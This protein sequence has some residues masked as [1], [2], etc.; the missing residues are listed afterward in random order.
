VSGAQVRDLAGLRR[1][2]SDK[3]IAGVAGGIARHL[4]IDPLLVRVL[5][6]VL[7]FFGG[8]GLIVYAACWLLAPLD[9]EPRGVLPLD[10]GSRTV[11]LA[12]A[13]LLAALSLLGD[14]LGGYGFPWPVA[15]VGLVVVVVL[16]F[17][18]PA[19]GPT[20]AAAAAAD[21]A[22]PAA[23]PPPTYATSPAVPVPPARPRRPGPVLFWYTLAL[24]AIAIGV[25]ASVDLAGVDVAASAYPA[26]ALVT[27]G[28]ML[29]VGSF[30]GRPGGLIALGLL[31][32]AVT[33]GVTAGGEVDGGRIERTPTTASA[34]A[35]DYDLDVGEIVL[36]LSRVADPT[37]LDGRRID[38]DVGIGRIEVVV[39]EGID[40]T[41]LSD[42]G[43]GGSNVFGERNEVGSS[44]DTLSGA[45]ADAAGTGLVLDVSVG[46]G[47]IDITREGA[48]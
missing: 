39:P 35:S 7:V 24:V 21:P 37:S 34:V 10:D 2:R 33:A 3:K 9:G 15:V 30:W 27:S 48:R 31:S 13:G 45:P 4:D 22:A 43:A 32:A 42:L 16:L 18:G 44:T 41:V 20:A 11:A 23:Y 19:A 12:L 14:S 36:D 17:R 8:A 28:L 5:L 40:V 6:V 47:D 26:A 46:L 38:L 25:L 29:V 1:S